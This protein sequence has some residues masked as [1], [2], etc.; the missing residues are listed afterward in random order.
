MVVF[1]IGFMGSGKSF[2]GRELSSFLGVPCVDLDQFIE[3]EQ[4]MS[5]TEIFEK[6]GESAFRSLESDALKQVYA[7]LLARPLKFQQKND[8][9]GI[10]SC[11]GG[12]PCFNGNMEWMNQHGVTIW[13]NPSED[14]LLERL[15]R[16]KKTRPLIANL[17]ENELR[18][19]I[20]KKMLERK[21]YYQKSKSEVS[22][23][24][25]TIDEFLNTIQHA[26]NIL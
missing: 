22:N 8:I 25:I 23:P 4:S 15:V 16:E 18:N 14:I 9:L 17:P 7:D 5:V 21:P 1:L 20:H 6:M 2:Y 12:T 10:I 13:V 11:G 3:Q 24:N 26:K 19:F